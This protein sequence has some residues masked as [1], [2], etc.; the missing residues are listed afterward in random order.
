MK[1]TL[2]VPI[3]TSRRAEGLSFT[4][5]CRVRPD[6]PVEHSP[7]LRP[8]ADALGRKG[9]I[10]V[11]PERPR[12]LCWRLTPAPALAAFQAAHLDWGC[13]RASAFGLSPGLDSAGPLGRVLLRALNREETTV[14]SS[15]GR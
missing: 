13:P 15:I 9:D 2:R 14:E 8:K 11:R 6:R 5:G 10:P 7:G 1:S 3:K 12:E 4:A